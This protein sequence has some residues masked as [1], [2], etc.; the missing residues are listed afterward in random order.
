MHW[1]T[2]KF[3]WFIWLQYLLYCGGLELYV[4]YLQ[5]MPA[6]WRYC[7]TIFLLALFPKINL[8]SSLS[9]FPCVL[10]LFLQLL[11]RLCLYWWLVKFDYE[12]PWCDVF[13]VFVFRVRSTS[14]ICGFIFLTKFG[15]ISFI[16][17]LKNFFLCF[18]LYSSSGIPNIHI[19]GHLKLSYSWLMILSS[20]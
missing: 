3:M 12:V 6:L 11:S 8:L 5:D 10:Y 2:K 20:F 14:W 15:K 17:S 4:Q 19:L 7:S 9:L 16:I 13:D 18:F 1:E